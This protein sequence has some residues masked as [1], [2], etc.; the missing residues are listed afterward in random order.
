MD[1]ASLILLLNGLINLGLDIATRFAPPP[2]TPE[3][4]KAQFDAL[5][6]KLHEVSAAVA[7]WQPIR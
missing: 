1:P 7:A 2:G 5:V 3:E 6:S 4:E